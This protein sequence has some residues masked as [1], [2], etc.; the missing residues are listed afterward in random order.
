VESRKAFAY[1]LVMDKKPITV[2]QIRMVQHVI[3]DNFEELSRFLTS[4]YGGE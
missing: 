4:L 1:M 2:T 3:D